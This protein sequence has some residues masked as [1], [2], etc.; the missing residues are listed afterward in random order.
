MMSLQQPQVVTQ[1][2]NENIVL[3]IKFILALLEKKMLT[4]STVG[5]KR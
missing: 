4:H 1:S 2:L 3:K 5:S